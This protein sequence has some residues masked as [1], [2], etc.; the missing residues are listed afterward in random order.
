MYERS[1]KE[2]KVPAAV[3]K[4]LSRP[5]NCNNRSLSP[6]FQMNCVAC[7]LKNAR[8]CGKNEQIRATV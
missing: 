5:F 7:T 2:R 4:Q 6:P 3:R 1:W 8:L